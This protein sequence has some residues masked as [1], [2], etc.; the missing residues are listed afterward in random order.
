[1]ITHVGSTTIFVDD[2]DKAVD[3]YVNKLGF[4]LRSD[5]PMGPDGPRWIEVGPAGGQTS[6]VL[7]RPTE[8]MPGASTYELAK[9]LI[10]TFAS[11]IFNVDDIQA[12]YKELNGRGV[13]F[14]DPPSQQPWGWWA[15]LMDSAGNQIGLH[16]S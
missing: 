6:L 4:E 13:E 8:A 15:T 2:Q 11:F 10:G 12:T 16:Q 9:S 3:F 14:P 1:M 5:Q 7:Y